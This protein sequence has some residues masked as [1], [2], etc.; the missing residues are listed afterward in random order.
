MRTINRKI[1][2]RLAFGG[3]VVAVCFIGYAAITHAL[4]SAFPSLEPERI[5]HYDPEAIPDNVRKQISPITDPNGM[6]DT[7]FF[8]DG[9]GKGRVIHMRFPK[10]YVGSILGAPLPRVGD[11]LVFAI[12]YPEMISV[13]TPSIWH[14]MYG[15]DGYV[16]DEVIEVGIKRPLPT[17][18]TDQVTVFQEHVKETKTRFPNIVFTTIPVPAGFTTAG[19]ERCQTEGLREV[20]QYRDEATTL[21]LSNKVEITDTY[22]ERDANGAVTREMQCQTH[23]ARPTCGI[24]I[25]AGKGNEFY[26]L[27]IVFH[28]RYL[29]RLADVIDRTAHL[30]NSSV[31]IDR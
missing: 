12:V 29:N 13:A 1:L 21:K 31:V 7:F 22:I 16:P 26:K 8:P 18:L 11:S 25:R 15:R 20:V 6:K 9:L 10:N 24:E 28:M 14:R 30:I 23:T 5:S 2:R 4:R 3:I 19:C 27:D 17:Y